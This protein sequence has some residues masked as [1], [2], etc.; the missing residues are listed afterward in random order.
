MRFV[1]LGEGL[2]LELRVSEVSTSWAFGAKRFWIYGFYRPCTASRTRIG[3]VRVRGGCHSQFP[4]LSL[5]SLHR[6]YSSLWFYRVKGL[7]FLGH[8]GLR[9]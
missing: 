4:C 8:P 5:R 1:G 6:F 7:Q 2:G 3:T 9:V